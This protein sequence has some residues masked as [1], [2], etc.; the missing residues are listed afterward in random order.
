MFASY[1]Q[2]AI[3]QIVWKNQIP[4]PQDADPAM[5]DHVMGAIINHKGNYGKILS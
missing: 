3:H 1:Y 2:L 4:P 5:E